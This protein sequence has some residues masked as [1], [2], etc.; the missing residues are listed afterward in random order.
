MSYNES[1]NPNSNYPLMS[2]SQ[3]DSA[4]FNEVDV[5]EQDF[6]VTCSQT[7]SKTVTIT[8]NN[9]IPGASGVDYEPNDEGGYDAVGW[10]DEDDTSDTDWANEYHDNDYHT[11]LQLIQLL[12]QV[13]ETNLQH[14]IVFKSP[15]FTQDLI[16]ECADWQEDETE[17]IQE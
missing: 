15:K 3:W 7:L 16:N 8:T 17:Y 11:P 14:G 12:K 6:D 2:Q 13:L 5:P 10:H 4:P 1:L 9:Y